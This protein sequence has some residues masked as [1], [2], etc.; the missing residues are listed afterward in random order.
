MKTIARVLRKALEGKRPSDIEALELARTD[1][2]QQLCAAAAM[3]RDQHWPEIITYSPKVFIPLTRLCRDVCGYCTFTE[4][5]QSGKRAY[6]LPEEVLDIAQAGAAAGCREA[7]FTLGDRPEQR[8]QAARGELD[9]LGFASTLHYLRHVAELVLK[10]T[11][12][13]PHLNPGNMSREEIEMLRPVCASMGIMLESASARLCARGGAHFGSLDKAPEARIATIRDAGEA[14]IPFTTGILIGIGETRLERIEALL[15]IRQ[16]HERHGHIQ[17]VIV[18][19][20]L[21]KP[22]T[23]MATHPP[24]HPLDHVWTAAVARIILGGE[25]SVQAPPNLAPNHGPALLDAGINDWGGVSPVT[26][27][28]VNPEA[29]W[30]QIES[31]AEMTN[32]AGKALAPRLPIYPAYVQ[33]LQRWAAP[34][35]RPAILRLQDAAGLARED[36]WTPGS[37]NAIPSLRRGN[38]PSVSRG[39]RAI[40]QRS[41]AG[42]VLDLEDIGALFAARDASFYAVCARAD[43]IRRE[44]N[45]E[46]V[47]YVVTRNI[48]Y[49]NVCTYRCRFC[50]FSKGSARDSHRERSYD[51]S[52]EEF[53]R[54]VAEAWSR[55][56]TEVCLQGGIHPDY[57]G[58]TYLAI[59]RAA[60]AAAPDIHV[61]AFSPLEI[62][63]GAHTL[64]VSL[65]DYLR[66]LKAAGLAS[67][68]GTAAEVLDDEV[69]A[70][71]CPDKLDSDSWFKVMETAHALGI[72]STATIMFGHV[73]RPIHWARHLVRLREHQKRLG[74]FTEFVPLPF[75]AHEAPIYKRG[76]AR[77]GPT[78]REAVL[79]H[80][81]AR[82]ALHPHFRHIQT[83][84]V[85]M[86]ALGARAC[87]EAGADDL[88][89]TLMNESITRAA[90]AIH[91]QEFSPQQM[92]ELIRAAGRIPVQRT[93]LYGEVPEERIL[94]SFNAARLTATVE[95][96][97]RKR[98]ASR[99]I[100]IK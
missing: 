15:A 37:A 58:E 77:L 100:D 31:L 74:G 87:L 50:A 67:L 61:H 1:D 24:A 55:G 3:I 83:S 41:A 64:G 10:R 56:G 38:N 45:G 78:W 43:E 42:A 96:P 11:G 60:K 82:I 2:R 49:T 84:W 40:L 51:L 27:D 63:Q 32:A 26:V 57:T 46:I 33:E 7:L 36:G 76:M 17:E 29:P 72:K 81:I 68:P 22:D 39:I 34:E 23:R 95:T 35:M 54:R 97:L 12:L 92:T 9:E 59:L 21:P 25:I 44:V 66:R 71:I 91:G 86:G 94:A 13:L 79:M 47:H 8:W 5:P 20:F 4:R 70:I 80:A 88:G 85:K 69:R 73:E 28:H 89:G 53:S 14:G 65:G 90:G 99:S 62:W 18:Q 6:L 52:E 75:V 19:N 16:L 93:T 48:N 30:P 98:A